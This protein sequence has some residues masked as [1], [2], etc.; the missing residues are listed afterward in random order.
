ML[1]GVDVTDKAR[2]AALGLLLKWE[3]EGSFANLLVDSARL[4]AMEARERALTVALFYG[5][6]ERTLTLDHYIGVLAARQTA[7]LDPHTRALCRMGLYQL[8][9]TDIPAHAA[10]AETVALGRHTGERALLNGVLRRAAKEPAA[11]TPPPRERN[12]A[13]HL[14]IAH[15]IPVPT[16]RYFLDRLGEEECGALLAAFN[17]RP[18]LALRVNTQRTDAVSLCTRFAKEGIEAIPDPLAPYGLLL[19]AG[20]SVPHLPGYREGD[21][22]VQDTASQLASALL[23]PNAGDTVLDLCACP[24]GKSFGAALMMGD[25]GRVIARD[26]HESK[27]SLITDGAARLGLRSVTAARWDAA[28]PDP[29]LLGKVDRVIADVPCS[30]IGVI[31][32]KPDLRYRGLLSVDELCA[33]SP[34]I[35]DA[36]AAA[37]RTGGLMVFSTCTLTH[38]ENED[39][40]AA[41]LDRHPDFIAEDFA[42]GD[43]HSSDGMLTL[44]PHRHATDGFFMAKLRRL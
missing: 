32:K 18:P 7:E 35:L 16:V 33:L 23:A 28:V 8:L 27:L 15:S 41:F 36:G 34:R 13:R 39:T 38:E 44:W 12:L 5:T 24:G 11:L 37:L 2:A 20:A 26:I 9:Y 3:S 22:F 42:F 14:S 6:V 29:A 31:A 17:K 30:G 1:R 40:V 25:N 43:L 21:F 4:D 19:P 10:V